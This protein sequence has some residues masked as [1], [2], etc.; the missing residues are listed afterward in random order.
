M[1]GGQQSWVM[2]LVI[3]GLGLMIFVVLLLSRLRAS[4]SSFEERF[5]VGFL[6]PRWNH[7]FNTPLHQYLFDVFLLRQC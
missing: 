1:G 5:S 2:L 4:S 3:C 7:S 6:A